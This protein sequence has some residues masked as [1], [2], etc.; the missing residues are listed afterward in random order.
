PAQ[1]GQRPS[2]SGEGFTVQRTGEPSRA[3]RQEGG[4]VYQSLSFPTAITAAKSGTLEIP[5][6]SLPAQVQ[7]PAQVPGGMQDLFGGLFNFGL[8]ETREI[9]IRTEPARIE[10]RPLPTDGQPKTFTGAIG[11]F[12]MSVEVS[13]KTAGPGDPVPLKATIS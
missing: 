11:D 12:R 1:F 2:F 6:A 7:V 10:V 3:T 9:E 13:P 4:A 5:P 8:T